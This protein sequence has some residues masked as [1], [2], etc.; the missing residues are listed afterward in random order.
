MAL[1]N[2]FNRMGGVRA[3]LEST[4][5]VDIDGMVYVLPPD[6]N[7]GDSYTA[8]QLVDARVYTVKSTRQIQPYS[9][10]IRNRPYSRNHFITETDHCG[11]QYFGHCTEVALIVEGLFCTTS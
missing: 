8:V 7:K 1:D 11:D 4:T 3:E 6:F 10:L 5:E 9:T 2:F